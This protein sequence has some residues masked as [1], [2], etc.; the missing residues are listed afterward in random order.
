M[1]PTYKISGTERRKQKSQLHELNRIIKD[2]WHFRTLEKDM[3]SF[4]GGI[5]MS[6]E[7]VEKRYTQLCSQSNELKIKLAELYVEDCPAS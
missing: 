6:D 2:F 4:Y 5:I 7:D 1:N 3:H